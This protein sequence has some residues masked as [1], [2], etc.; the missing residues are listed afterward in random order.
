MKRVTKTLKLPE[1]DFEAEVLK[2]DN[3]DCLDLIKIYEDWIKLNK[4]L[5]KVGARAVNIPE[6]LTETA[7][8]IAKG[9]WRTPYK[10]KKKGKQK[11]N[12][13]FD[14]YDNNGGRKNNR[15]QIKACSVLPD[16]TSFGPKSEWDRI[17][18]ADFYRKGKWNKKFDLYEIDT[19]KI[20]NFKVNENETVEQQKNQKR[21]P[22]FSIYNGLIE[23]GEY[24]SKET[25][26]ITD[27]G[28]EKYE[29]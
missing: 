3:G 27:N 28:V 23:Q 4:K 21:R 22:R 8:C 12:S 7:V 29:K 14:C 11:I 6:G 9:F 19:E 20:M 10:I 1:G 16:L 17:F 2:F 5:I 26:I 15:I 18:F 25:Y 24:I 13:S